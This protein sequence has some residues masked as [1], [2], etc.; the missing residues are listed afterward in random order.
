MACLSMNPPKNRHGSEGRQSGL[1]HFEARPSKVEFLLL[2]RVWFG[3][4]AIGL[5]GWLW[6]LGSNLLDDQGPAALP[7]RRCYSC[8][9]HGFALYTYAKAIVLPRGML[10]LREQAG[11]ASHVACPRSVRRSAPRHTPITLDRDASQVIIVSPH[12]L[13]LCDSQPS[14]EASAAGHCLAP[15]TSSI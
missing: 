1:D 2:R 3:I 5:V 14:L 13:C 7:L 11:G 6:H 15:P 9:Y 8:R 12:R 10:E 4:L